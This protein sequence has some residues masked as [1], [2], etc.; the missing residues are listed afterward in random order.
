MMKKN[1]TLIIILALISVLCIAGAGIILL[2]GDRGDNDAGTGLQQEK[3]HGSVSLVYSDPDVIPDHSGEDYIILNDGIP[4]FNEWDIENIT[5]E[6]YSEPDQLGR[7]GAAYAILDRS[8]MPTGER[9]DIGQ[10]K[11]TGWVQNKYEGIVDS[12]PPYLFNRSHLIA[13]DLTGQNA[14][15]RNLITGTRYMNAVTQLYWE[16]KVMRYLD[17]SDNHALYRVTPL[18][19]GDELLARG[20]E[21][22]AYSVEDKGASLCFHVFVYNIQPGIVLDYSTGDNRAE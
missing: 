22:E 1:N 13:Y 18:F 7:C 4:C 11:P 20:V 21:M 10:I 6:H 12:E 8:M 9:E 16:K 17:E 5:G 14:N 3:T 15:E 2:L 19:K